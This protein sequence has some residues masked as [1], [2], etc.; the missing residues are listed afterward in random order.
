[1][2]T[3]NDLIEAIE[4]VKQDAERKGLDISEIPIQND[5]IHE[6]NA[7]EMGLSDYLGHPY[8]LIDIRYRE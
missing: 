6:A 2:I 5:F 1:M 4:Q 3:L 7:I 8:I